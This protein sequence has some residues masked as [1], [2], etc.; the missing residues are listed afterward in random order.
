MFIGKVIT[1]IVIQALSL[2]AGMLL[3]KDQKEPTLNDDK[4]TTSS[5][6]GSMIPILKGKKRI[7]AIIG[8]VGDRVITKE[9]SGSGGKKGGSKTTKV[10]IYNESAIHFLCVGP[11]YSLTKIW[12]NG[13]VIWEGE[14][15][16]D[17][18]PDKAVIDLGKEGTFHLYW[19]TLT[20]DI[21]SELGVSYIENTDY[22]QQISYHDILYF[23]TF[24][25]GLPAFEE[26]RAR[27]LE[28]A[29]VASDYNIS[30]AWRGVCYGVWIKRRL[31]Y[32]PI[33]SSIDYEITVK[34][35]ETL[36]P[37]IDDWMTANGEGYNPASLLREILFSAS[38]RGMQ[39]PTGHFDLD[40][41]ASVG[42]AVDA[43]GTPCHLMLQN[44][45]SWKASVAA[46][47]QDFGILKGRNPS[48]G[49]IE[50][51]LI[52]ES[53][54]S[55]PDIPYGLLEFGE[56]ET[57]TS[58]YVN[59]CE[60]TVYTFTDMDR[61]FKETTVVWGS[62][63]ILDDSESPKDA[64]VQMATI[65]DWNT[66]LI[67]SERRSQEDSGRGS[68]QKFKA[69][70]EALLM[71]PGQR[72]R[73]EGTVPLYILTSV[74]MK[75]DEGYAELASIQDIYGLNSRLPDTIGAGG[76]DLDV[77]EPDPAIAFLETNRYQSPDTL[78]AYL[79]RVRDSKVISEASIL[80]SLDSVTYDDLGANSMISL[81]GTLNSSMGGD[82]ALSLQE[83]GPEVTLVGDDL[84]EVDNYT[85]AEAGWRNGYQLCVIDREFMFLR[86]IVILSSTTY[87]LEGIIRGRFGSRKVEH[88][89]G[90]NVFI[91]DQKYLVPYVGDFL[92]AGNTV[93]IKTIPQTWN[94]AINESV[95]TT[96]S[97][98]MQGSGYRPM[99]PENLNSSDN[100]L[101]WDAGND[102][103]LK[104]SFRNAS[105]KASG[106]GFQAAGTAIQPVLPEGTFT[107]RI[108]DS[109]GTTLKRTVSSLDDNSYTYSN[110]NMVSDF[111]SEPSEILIRLVN[112]LNGL[113]SEYDESSFEKL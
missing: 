91:F 49:L 34:P 95:A 52:R 28:R 101:S 22:Q 55:F 89:A 36:I 100:L 76:F 16:R 45:E 23:F 67:V 60:R 32:S 87:Q 86:N 35:T 15:T 80:L 44:G 107:L 108:Y 54:E 109:T 90:S 37:G 20:Q 26:A 96:A 39:L 27:V 102:L 50:F 8:W 29:A 57:I 113:E 69:S 105:E 77:A 99:S 79:F 70:R 64:K 51:S 56:P 24:G 74:I 6:R 92:A 3:R 19:G 83:E 94:D 46:L 63:G 81:G 7:G 62:E 75:P 110:G 47:M 106:A 66:A 30:S 11:A 53:S 104:W 40:S 98:A 38:P 78:A 10:T 84:D 13:E 21:P 61:N 58:H 111:G 112:T 4:A 9:K 88:A 17:T 18:N 71:Y 31:G 48:T 25:G 1:F 33:W 103:D 5:T 82:T 42:V 93:S 12:V 65:G 59:S 68:A 73:I 41:L 14:V 97:L 85:G 72:F 2:M 43:E